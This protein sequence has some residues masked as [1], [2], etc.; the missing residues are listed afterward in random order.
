LT[1]I[2]SAARRR[3]WVN[4]SSLLASTA[5]GREPAALALRGPAPDQLLPGG[6][7]VP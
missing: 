6:G 7:E 4:L 2:V 1:L 3:S 5:A